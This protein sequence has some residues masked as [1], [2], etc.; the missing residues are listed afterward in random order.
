MKSCIRILALLAA[1]LAVAGTAF[2]ESVFIGNTDMTTAVKVGEGLYET[3]VKPDSNGIAITKDG[4]LI[5]SPDATGTMTV[6]NETEQ[7]EISVL[8]AVLYDFEEETTNGE[9]VQFS[10]ERTEYDGG[11]YSNGGVMDISAMALSDGSVELGFNFC[12]ADTASADL[13]NITAGEETVAQI[14]LSK[15]SDTAV[16][17]SYLENGKMVRKRDITI[18]VGEWLEAEAVIDLDAKTVDLYIDGNLTITAPIADFESLSQLVFETGVDD[19]SLLTGEVISE[20]G[21]EIGIEDT[22]I[23]AGGVYAIDPQVKIKLNDEWHDIGAEY[24][25]FNTEGTGIMPSEGKILADSAAEVKIAC[26]VV[27]SGTEYKAEKTVTVTTAETE[28]VA[29]DSLAVYQPVITD[30]KI[31]LRILNG[32]EMNLKIIVCRTD[33]SGAMDFTAEDWTPDSADAETELDFSG[34]NPAV[35]VIDT[36]SGANLL[37]QEGI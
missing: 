18:N 28:C 24:I 1:M 37:Q 2:A 26:S 32:E 31:K 13:I 29:C 36:D 12:K 34:E 7:T 11:F 21:L 22:E 5:I 25:S 19:I 10:G 27:V 16:Y 17:F 6:A 15:R 3:V 4:I 33:E 9:Y 23:P 14:S 35:F 8:P 20:S 30:G